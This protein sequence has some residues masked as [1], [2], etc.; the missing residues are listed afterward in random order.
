MNFKLNSF[1]FFKKPYFSEKSSFY[2]KKNKTLVFKINRNIN[3]TEILLAVEK[4]F[5]LKVKKIR[6]LW[7]KGKRKNKKNGLVSYTKKWKKIYV[8]LEK[9]QNLELNSLLK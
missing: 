3:K 8:I 2:L 9:N 4:I 6:T 5:K 1:S 7:V